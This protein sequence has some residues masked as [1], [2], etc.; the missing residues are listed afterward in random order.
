MVLNCKENKSLCHGD[1]E[2]EKLIDLKDE[3]C[4][5]DPYK[6]PRC[7]C[8]SDEDQN[9][10]DNNGEDTNEQDNNGED[11]NEQDNNGEDT[12]EQDNNEEDTNRGTFADDLPDD[13]PEY[14]K[15]ELQF[16]YKFTSLR[17][18]NRIAIGHSFDNFVQSCTFKAQ[19]C[20]NTT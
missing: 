5:R 15:A 1:V 16:L 7:T 6:L 14:Y 2:L 3:A 12:N 9:G 18:D 4:L 11:A 10:Q 8:K 17:T 19:D 20:R 13:E